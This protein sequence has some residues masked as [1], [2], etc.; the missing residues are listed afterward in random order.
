[1]H[2]RYVSLSTWILI[3][4]L[5]ACA[6]SEQVKLLEDDRLPTDAP[7]TPEL[8]TTVETEIEQ[9]IP[10]SD[11]PV[12]TAEN[13]SFQAPEPY[14]AVAPWENIFWHG[15][16]G[17]W[18]AL[19]ADGIWASLPDNP[20]GYTQKIMWWSS[21]YVLKEELQPNL[22]VSGRRLDAEAPPLKF[23]GATNAFAEDIGDAMLTG[24]DFPTLGC[25]EVT[26]QY[27]KS[28]LKFVVWLAP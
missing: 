3:A 16:E 5:T 17:L 10:P 22:I 1:M 9:R 23:Y 8:T 11:C 18:T 13:A 19:H 20:E 28:E 21:S 12:T 27:K 6:P 15:T 4:F 7:F 14:A 2:K 26:G 25:W 24:V